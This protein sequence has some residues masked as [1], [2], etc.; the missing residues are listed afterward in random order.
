MID[1][2]DKGMPVE[3]ESNASLITESV[4]EL[5]ALASAMAAN[6]EDAFQRANFHLHKLG[7][8][9]EDRIKAVNI[10]IQV[11]MVPYNNLMDMAHGYL[12]GAAVE[13]GCGCGEGGCECGEGGCECGE[14][15]C[16]CGDGCG[17][18]D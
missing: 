1:E 16:A 6:N 2:S 17:S 12:T 14:D 7:V 8:S 4:A 5:V 3:S 11:K 9:R 10:A 18:G 15:E 13:G